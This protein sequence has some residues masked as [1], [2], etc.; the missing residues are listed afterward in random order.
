MKR[1]FPVLFLLLSQALL[2]PALLSQD[3]IVE[4]YPEIFVKAAEEQKN[5]FIVFSHQNCGWCRVFD[6]YH[7]T[8]EV[9]E[10]LEKNYVI[11]IIDITDSESKT[12][13]WKQYDFIGVPG[14]LIYSSD[15]ELLSNGKM[16]DG[17]QV[18][19]PLEPE[20]MEMYINA[21]SETSRHVSK[22]ELRVL[23]KKIVYCDKHY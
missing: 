23:R 7:E 2:P 4:A 21:I 16:E 18:G 10:I 15:K 14:W 17:E 9:K 8:P 19:Y 12:A 5:V 11:E 1:L 22:K 13:L 6:R 3:G 20:G